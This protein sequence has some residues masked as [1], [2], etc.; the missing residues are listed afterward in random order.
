MGRIK[1]RYNIQNIEEVK[2]AFDVLMVWYDMNVTQVLAAMNDNPIVIN[3]LEDW[4]GQ[5]QNKVQVT[6]PWT[7]GEEL[8]IGNIRSYNDTNYVVIQA[9]TTQVDWTPDTVPALFLARP[10]RSVGYPEWVQP[11]GSHDAYNIGDRVRHNN[12]NW[13]STIDANVWEPGVT[14]WIEI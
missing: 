3:N 9:H 6:K 1:L 2:K 12:Q 13:E 5:I 14:G 4:T 11:A 7:V 10:N 8:Q